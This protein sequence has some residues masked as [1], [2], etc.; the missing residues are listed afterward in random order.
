MTS[1]VSSFPEEPL[2]SSDSPTPPAERPARRRPWLLAGGGVVLLLAALAVLALPVAGAA[3]DAEAA[4]AELERGVS[5]LRDDDLATAR[6]AVSNA[7]AHV[8]DAGEAMHG[9]GADVWSHVPVAGQAVRDARHLVEALDEVTAVAEVGT[10]LYPAVAGPRATLFH[11][12]QVDRETLDRV[13]AGSQEVVDRLRAA[14]ASLD[15]VEATTPLVGERLASGR[16]VASEQVTP[17]LE[18]LTAVAPAIDEL[19]KVLGFD[20]TRHYLLAL[21]NPADQR[22]SSGT[23]LAF[24]RMT[25]DE[26]RLQVGDSVDIRANPR[27]LYPIEWKRVKGNYFHYR[28][29]PLQVRNATFA[30]SWSIGGEE[31]IRGWKAATGDDH[32]GVLAIDVVALARLFEV[33]GSVTV[34]GLGELT[35]ENLVEKLVGSY[36]DYYPDPNILDAYAA[37]I[38]E[39]FR[40]TLFSGGQYVA[41]ARALGEAAAGRHLA[42]YFRDPEVQ[43][44]VASLGL[45]GDLA[46]PVG[47]YLGVFTQSVL[48]SKSDYWQE[49]STELDVTLDENGGATNRLSVRIHNDSPPYAVPGTDPGEGYFTRWAGIAL[50]V[51][52]PDGADVTQVRTTEQEGPVGFVGNFYD[53]DFFYRNITLE[54]QARTQLT[55]RYRVDDAA[56]V[57]EDG[58]LTY[59]LAMDPQGL[60]RDQAV[61]VT[62][63]LPESYA[64]TDLPEGWSAQGATLT[65]DVAD[66]AASEEWEIRA[67]PAD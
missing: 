8:D 31:L 21:L 29:Q 16:D 20:G 34:P 26:G 51:F 17:L 59:R 49:R 15:Q 28:Q 53:H 35:S 48:P 33:T 63:H 24:S 22:Y 66:L 47:D 2:I 57:E 7:R 6:D 18:S 55:A 45:D 14:E 10:E 40:G 11:D 32:D 23:P 50:G 60:V 1:S 61:T 64:A 58:A 42:L 44:A 9:W 36:D 38:I 54:P 62:L 19:P 65:Y 5:A 46:P 12:D 43:E 52:V 4:R 56:T 39:P 13:I 67:A 30:P 37:E 27:L 3:G 25:W 41:K